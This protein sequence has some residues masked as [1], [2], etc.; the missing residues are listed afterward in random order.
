MYKPFIE[1]ESMILRDFRILK[2]KS[3]NKSR[4][5]IGYKNG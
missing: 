4:P 5:A 2:K 3:S 1:E